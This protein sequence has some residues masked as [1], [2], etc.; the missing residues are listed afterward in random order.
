MS[1]VAHAPVRVRPLR[2]SRPPAVRWRS[3]ETSLV[4]PAQPPLSLSDPPE[5]DLARPSGRAATST[6]VRAR[7]TVRPRRG[8]PDACEWGAALAV[9]GVPGL[10]APRPIAPPHPWL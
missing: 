10:L 4:S 5:V 3:L 6:L 7:W 2:E 9:A 8:L 1:A